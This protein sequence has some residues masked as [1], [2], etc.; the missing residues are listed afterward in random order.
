MEANQFRAALNSM[1]ES[2]LSEVINAIDR[3]RDHAVQLTH[4]ARL[5]ECAAFGAIA[6]DLEYCLRIICQ[7]AT[8]ENAVKVM[9]A[10]NAQAIP[11]ISLYLDPELGGST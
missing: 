11:L 9:D 5:P 2:D 7:S 1:S 6:A 3:A 8:A 10:D 4:S